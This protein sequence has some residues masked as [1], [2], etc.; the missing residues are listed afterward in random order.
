MKHLLI[1]GAMGQ[2]GQSFT[3]IAKQWPQ[4]QFTFADKKLADITNQLQMAALLRQLK[5]YAVINCAAFTNV[6][7]AEQQ[8]ELAYAVNATAVEQLAQL[9]RE[10][11]TLLVH[12]STDYVFSG[13]QLDAGEN[14]T[15]YT[16]QDLAEPLNVYGASKLAGEQAMLNIAPAGLILRSSWLYSAFG[17]NFAR[18]IYNKIQQGLPLRVVADQIGSPTYAPE[19]AALCLKLLSADHFATTQ[20]LHCAGQGEASWYQVAQE[21]QKY[22]KQQTT[23]TAISSNQWQSAATRPSYSALSSQQLQKQFGLSL[24]AWQQSLVTCLN[25]MGQSD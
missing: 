1:T 21:I 5:P 18:I 7:L 16:E 15:P 19:L 20:L 6:D 9:C 23:L 25:K 3:A 24:P 2:L 22:T 4:F 12:F 13:R 8:P 17:H 14:Q 10:T 11:N